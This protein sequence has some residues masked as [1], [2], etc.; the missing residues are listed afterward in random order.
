MLPVFAAMGAKVAF[1]S[2]LPK[3]RS[4]KGINILNEKRLNNMDKLINKVYSAIWP[5]YSL[6]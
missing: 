4:I 3:M 1:N 6:I 5:L 2:A